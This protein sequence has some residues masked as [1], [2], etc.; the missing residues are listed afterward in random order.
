M[1]FSSGS[2]LAYH[3]GHLALGSFG[4]ALV[5]A[6]GLMGPPVAGMTLLLASRHR[7]SAQRALFVLGVLLLAFNADLGVLFIR[8]AGD[9]SARSCNPLSL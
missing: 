7:K 2:E 4:R 1:I 3:G 9:T 6:G 5:S 8:M